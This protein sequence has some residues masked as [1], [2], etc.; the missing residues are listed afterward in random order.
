MSAHPEATPRPETGS[1]AL[2]MAE[3][4]LLRR[5]SISVAEISALPGV[6]GQ[7]ESFALLN[8]LGN[9]YHP[10]R[11]SERLIEGERIRRSPTITLTGAPDIRRA[12]RRA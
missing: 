1:L 3:A 12:A 6:D 9:M 5:G 11:Y 10:V 7:E 4:L 2:R 8:R